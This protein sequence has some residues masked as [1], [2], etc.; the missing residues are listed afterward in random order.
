[1]ILAKTETIYD[2]TFNVWQFCSRVGLKWLELNEAAEGPRASIIFSYDNALKLSCR[3]KRLKIQNLFRENEWLMCYL[4]GN[5]RERSLIKK[6]N[7]SVVDDVENCKV[8]RVVLLKRIFMC[9]QKNFI[10]TTNRAKNT[11]TYLNKIV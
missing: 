3:V 4:W 5:C 8:M 10:T 6:A 9:L 11:C 7:F 1:M 2:T